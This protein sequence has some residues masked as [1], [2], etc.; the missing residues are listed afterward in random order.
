MLATADS[1]DAPP[2][3]A[4]IAK[5]AGALAA[6]SILAAGVCLALFAWLPTLNGTMPWDTRPFIERYLAAL[7]TPPP[8]L[9]A[10]KS[11]LNEAIARNPRSVALHRQMVFINEQLHEPVEDEVRTILS[12]DHTDMRLRIGLATQTPSLPAAERIRILNE[13]LDLDAQLPPGELQHLTDHEKDEIHAALAQLQSSTIPATS[14][15]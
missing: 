1:Y 3:R 11:A 13:T 14:A 12:L 2:R 4:A 10:A 7:T 5:S 8:D 15:Q 6:A 9:A